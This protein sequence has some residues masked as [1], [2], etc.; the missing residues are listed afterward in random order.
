MKKT[1]LYKHDIEAGVLQGFRRD[2]LK[3]IAPTI[4]SSLCLWGVIKLFHPICKEFVPFI[5]VVFTV[6]YIVP[7]SLA[8]IACVGALLS[9]LIRSHGVRKG[10]LCICTD[11]LMLKEL[12]EIIHRNSITHRYTLHFA[13]HGK[14]AFPHETSDGLINS[15]R[16]IDDWRGSENEYLHPWG[17]EGDRF[18]LIMVGRRICRVYPTELFEIEE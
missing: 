4:I 14:F 12:V 7:C 1:V 16:D 3:L 11:T 5:R 2:A 13:H 9:S 17:K 15:W 18:Y 8:V 6:L 10:R